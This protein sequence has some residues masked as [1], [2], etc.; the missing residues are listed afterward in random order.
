MILFQQSIQSEV[1][2]PLLQSE[3]EV[4]EIIFS[5]LLMLKILKILTFKTMY[6]IAVGNIEKVLKC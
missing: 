1:C 3:P 5:D 2:D 6:H 4:L